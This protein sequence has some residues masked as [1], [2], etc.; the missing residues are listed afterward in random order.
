MEIMCVQVCFCSWC[1]LFNHREP[2]S[3]KHTMYCMF[4][5]SL[6][7]RYGVHAHAER[8][9]SSVTFVTEHHLVLVVRL[10]AHGAGLTLHTLPAVRL[11]HTHQLLAHVQAGRVA[12]SLRARRHMH[13]S[14]SRRHTHTTQ[15]MHR[16]T[17]ASKHKDIKTDIMW[18]GPPIYNHTTCE[19]IILLL[20]KSSKSL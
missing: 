15:H 2:I 4:V 1:L 20:Q 17:Q 10:L 16:H 9:V 12:W 14:S 8:V 6:T 3:V 7:I 11:D 19:Y 18:T 13:R 5:Y